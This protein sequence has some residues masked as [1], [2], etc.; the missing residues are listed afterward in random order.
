MKQISNQRPGLNNKFLAGGKVWL[1]PLL[2]G[3]MCVPAIS[4]SES[5]RKHTQPTPSPT[6]TYQAAPVSAKSGTTP[7]SPAA[8]TPRPTPTPTPSPSPS[9]S[10][11]PTSTPPARNSAEIIKNAWRELR[12]NRLD[13][14]LAHTQT[15]IDRWGAD[16]N[17]QQT[18][19]QQSGKCKVKPAPE[20][21]ETHNPAY[22]ALNDVAVAWIIRGRALSERKQFDQAREAFNRVMRQYDC[23]FYWDPEGKKGGMFVSAANSAQG[24]YNQIKSK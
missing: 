6:P 1:A 11:S 20:E 12:A 5:R 21:R 22:W 24:R 8:P 14:A 17:K 10:P 9:P 19:R 18:L 13:E 23:A 2:L 3:F 7:R 16:A 15:V 4:Q